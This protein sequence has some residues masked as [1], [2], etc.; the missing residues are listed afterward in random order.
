MTEKTT[1]TKKSVKKVAPKAVTKGGVS[2]ILVSNVVLSNL[3]NKRKAVAHT[4]TRA[5]VSGGGKK[6]W[7]QKGTGRA[8][9][10][11]NRS[12]LWIGGGTT[13]GPRSNRNFERSINKKQK[14]AV[15]IHLLEEKK[16]EGSLKIVND[17]K[18]ENSKTKNMIAF[19]ASQEINGNT[20]LVLDDV[21]SNSEEGTKIYESGRNISFLDVI[22][23]RK[24]NAFMVLKSKFVVITKKALEEIQSRKPTKEE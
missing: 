14:A 22:S 12:P 21:L 2:S 24:V 15:L 6:P 4:K 9:A 16:K 3:S 10:G 7:R 8:R 17:I 5:E 1:V 19:L 13:F 23:E 20:V 18:F 11:S